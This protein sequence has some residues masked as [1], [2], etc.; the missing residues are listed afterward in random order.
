MRVHFQRIRYDVDIHLSGVG[1]ALKGKQNR[2]KKRE[3][4]TKIITFK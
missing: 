4:K 1:A 2:D 3:D